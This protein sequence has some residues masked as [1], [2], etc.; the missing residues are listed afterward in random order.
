MPVH[1]AKY[2]PVHQ[3]KY[4]HVYAYTCIYL[5]CTCTGLERGIGTRILWDLTTFAMFARYIKD[6]TSTVLATF[7]VKMAPP[8]KGDPGGNGLVSPQP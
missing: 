6:T 8:T 2:T 4:M 3:A 5:A 7:A 1:Q